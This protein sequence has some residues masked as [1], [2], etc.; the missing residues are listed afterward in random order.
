MSDDDRNQIS[1]LRTEVY[2]LTW[3]C[4]LALIVSIVSLAAS[5]ARG[6]ELEKLPGPADWTG[7]AISDLVQLPEVDRPFQRYL[8]IPNWGNERWVPALN[9]GVNTA[10]SHAQTIHLGTVI[11]NGWMVRYDLRRLSPRADTFARTVAVWDSLARQDPYLHVP[12]SNVDAGAGLA[13]VAPSI[14]SDHAAVLANLSLSVGAVY[15]ADWFLVKA[16]STLNGGAYYDFRQVVRKPEKGSALDNWLSQRGLFVGTTQAVGGERRAA[17]FRS[18][19]TGKPRRVDVFPTL[20]GGLGS[21]TRDV[22]DGNVDATS[23]PLRNLLDFRDDGSEIIVAQ[24]NG[25]HDYLLADSAGNVVDEAPPDL[26][27]DHTIPPPHTS[28]LQPARSCISCHA[29]EGEDGWRAV[30]NDVQTLLS[31]QLNVFAD[32]SKLG[33]TREEAV[34]KLAGFYALDIEHA[35]G[36]LARARRDYSTAVYRCAAGIRFDESKSIAAQV[37]QLTTGIIHDYDYALVDPGRAA[38]EL[39]YRPS[40][41]WQGDLLSEVL[42]PIDPTVEA[43]P[44]VGFLRIGVSVNRTDWETVY[45]DA[46]MLAAKN[47]K[48][49]E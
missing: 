18:G 15:R 13:I 3:F 48:G 34:D 29:L 2:R 6:A 41:D 11:A 7:W 12:A 28:R 43:D 1:E 16:L 20:A 40:K 21:I 42:G 5:V 32:V 45:Q 23:H 4:A 30:R 37:G 24:P 9:Y 36:L 44:V 27:R 49:N 22:K 38:L 14:P 25:L 8:A 10:V 17:M 47:R 46:A 33:I 35:D 26:V 19:V 31:S 39:G